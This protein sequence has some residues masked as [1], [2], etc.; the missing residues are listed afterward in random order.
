MENF[1]ESEK[2]IT[3]R[4]VNAS[5]QLSSI[6]VPKGK[7][8]SCYERVFG[9]ARESKKPL[10]ANHVKVVCLKGFSRFFAVVSL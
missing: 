3:A 1:Q 6:A 5:G 10:Q 7:E 9:R 4:Q 2:V 8:V